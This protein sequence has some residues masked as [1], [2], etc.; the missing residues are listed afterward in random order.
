M[1]AS[2]LR[3]NGTEQRL[4]RARAWLAGRPAGEPVLVVAASP[5]AG[6]ELLRRVA[7]DATAGAAFGWQRETLGRLAAELATPALVERELASIGALAAE[8]AVARV[9]HELHA[10]GRL[11]R[12]ADAV[13]GPGL[14][15][16]V[17]RTL[18]ELR[19]ACVAPERL[20][21][22]APELAAI[23][24]AYA[25]EL[26]RARLADRAIVFELATH[27]ARDA[28][29][30]HALLGLPTLFVDVAIETAADRELVAA[31]AARAPE[32]LAT[33][34]PGD[35]TSAAQL[36]SALGAK[37]KEL[38]PRASAE[39]ALARLQ[40]HLFE[41]SAPPEGALDGEVVV[42][43][44]PGE[45]REC[46]EIA[47]RLHRFAAEGIP[48][49][50]MAILLRSP[51]EY[52]RHLEEAL[53]RADV[54]AWFAR[55]ST[56]PDPA[57]RAFLALL[58]CAAERLSARRFAEYLSLAQVPDADPSGAPPEAPPPGARWV[59]P[60]EELVPEGVAA[61][62]AATPPAGIQP[63][64]A[65]DSD[66]RPVR[67][68]TL[69]APRRWERLLMEAAVIGGRERW[70]RRLTGLDR[71][72][73]L[74]R[75]E[76]DDPDDPL[77]ARLDQERER[78][79]ALRDF[80]LPL[81]DALAA[82]PQRASWGDWLDALS[83]LATRTLRHPERVLSVLAELAPM[84]AIGPVGLE[85][86][87]LVLGRRL[88]ELE[89]KPPE[90]RQGRVL[91]APAEAARGL[92]FDVVFVPGLAERLFPRKVQ[93]EPIL[94]DADRTRLA[95]G[96]P[97]NETR[98]A[99]E[100]LA[101]RLAVGA[102]R[103]RAVLSY[104]R[105]DLQQ[106]RP[107]VP[108]FYALE[109]LR[110]AEG[111]LPGFDELAARAEQVTEARV[112]WPAPRAPEDAIDAA[113]H[114]LALLN[115]VLDQDEEKSVGAAH[116]LLEA[117]PHLGRALRF[118]ARRWLKRWTVADG[119]VP[120]G[121]LAQGALE[122]LAGHGLAARSFSP[123]ALQSFASCPY[124]FFLYTVHRLAP[125]EVP[126]AVDEL[127]PLQRGALVH[128]VQY[129]LFRRLAAEQ[130]LPVRPANLEPARAALDQVLDAVA[131]RHREELAPAIQRVWQNGIDSI[132]A[133]LREWLRRSAEDDSG[134]V[135]WRFELGFGLP[136][137]RERDPH[138]VA[139]PA[140]LDCGLRL[141]GSIDLVEKR[142]DGTLRVTDHKTGRV[143]FEEGQVI[144]GG[145]TLQPVLYA[146]AAE[147]LFPDQ[148]VESGR[149]SYCTSAGGFVDRVV[150]LD[151]TARA[152][153]EAVARVVGS[154]L[155]DPFLPALP[156]RNAC[157]FC[158]Y[159][160]VCGPYEEL[161]TRRKPRDHEQVRALEQLRGL[162]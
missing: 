79:T 148:E 72:L 46:V 61:A 110:A 90:S 25:A 5:E 136:G 89:V 122:A 18:G 20:N 14:P 162:S 119:L 60:D 113:E 24:V 82:L 152:R 28:R 47:R 133:D 26:E 35:E 91:V 36:A 9:L 83:A 126:E 85:E 66:T 2:L 131:S 4:A 115:D 96:L 159:A 75:S 58:A 105:L 102:A 32:M 149:L 67:A 86:V 138:S 134:F 150:R 139:E 27:A 52:R 59:A 22:V 76:L 94:L 41:D 117:N 151:A 74:Q 16:A 49:D 130:H 118:R 34:P 121:D 142:A 128:E 155:A 55:G 73:A 71:E 108:S 53:A 30:E 106:S 8:A 87:Q 51:D 33:L 123:T 43:S 161:R 45:G 124:R 132:R 125:R 100:R 11:G 129:E 3:A 144:A 145:E 63:E 6:A 29:H 157:R 56:R 97:T 42:F 13:G 12:Y 69:R 93:E 48:F 88:L 156:A 54:P 31:V 7:L 40:T 21:D 39:G 114:D 62:L 65:A 137:T 141:R 80:A 143:R 17:A 19:L 78:L 44:A 99:R 104:P 120:D 15:R 77:A 116:Y 23:A 158:D 109:A 10:A 95:A 103:Q 64:E 112:G 70:A 127:D 160:T 92:A 50:R 101:L 154:A 146:L 37:L 57:G 147:K 68:G 135:P 111:R 98:V 153:A 140:S 81:V 84:A 107:R 1:A 38:A